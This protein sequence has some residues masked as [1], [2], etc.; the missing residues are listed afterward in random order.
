MASPSEEILGRREA[1]SQRTLDVVEVL[2]CQG[3][4]R[5]LCEQM[6]GCGTSVGASVFETDEAMARK[7]FVKGLAIADG[8]LS[9]SRFWLRL[10]AGR[11]WVSVERLEPLPEETTEL[12]KIMG[13]MISRTQAGARRAESPN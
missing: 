11:G 12:R 3:R 9:E 10:V 7:D 2:E 5:R 8:E 1:F 4:S 13:T 6:T